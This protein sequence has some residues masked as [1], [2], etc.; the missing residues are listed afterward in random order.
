VLLTTGFFDVAK[1]TT[2]TPF[3][4]LILCKLLFPTVGLKISYLPK[5]ALKYPSKIFI[6]YV[7]RLTIR[8]GLARTVWV[9]W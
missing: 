6:W 1:F 9:F 4:L 5:L 8:S 2:L 7:G 3:S